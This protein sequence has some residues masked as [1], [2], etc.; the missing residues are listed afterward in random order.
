MPQETPLPA[1]ALSSI[2]RRGLLMI[3]SAPAATGK[4]T[5]AKRIL[6]EDNKLVESVSVT[7]RAPREGEVDGVDYHFITEEHFKEMVANNELLEHAFVHGMH[8]YGTPRAPVEKLLADGK[9]VLFV[10]EWQGAQQI[11]E[12][13]RQDLVTIFILPPS[14]AEM[15]RRI[16]HRGQDSEESIKKRM[17]NAIEEIGHA[18]EYGYVILN[19]NLEIA[20][21]NVRSVLK[22]ERRR[23]RRQL[24][25]TDFLIGLQDELRAKFG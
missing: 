24:G 15:E 18:G 8:H 11:A 25:L 23:R 19:D 2:K 6:A 21:N 13:M 10:I 9:D 17:R 5:I 12:K 20:I 16:R 22:A 7:T 1:P 14:A 4:N 3:M